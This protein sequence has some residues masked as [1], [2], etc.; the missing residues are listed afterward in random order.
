VIV[1]LIC[2]ADLGGSWGTLKNLH[3]KKIIYYDQNLCTQWL[4][5]D[6]NQGG[7]TGLTL[8]SLDIT[9]DSERGGERH[10]V[11]ALG[12]RKKNG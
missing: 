10:G 7:D 9:D 3:I 4:V 1:T 12:A 5:Y 6:R 2:L 11:E 8:G